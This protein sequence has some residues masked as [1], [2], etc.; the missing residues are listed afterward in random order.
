MPVPVVAGWSS[1]CAA[2]ASMTRPDPRVFAILGQRVPVCSQQAS[3]FRLN[4]VLGLVRT[5]QPGQTGRFL[6][7]CCGPLRPVMSFLHVAAILSTVKGMLNISTKLA[8][9]EILVPQKCAKLKQ[10]RRSRSDML[11]SLALTVQLAQLCRVFEPLS[12]VCCDRL[13]HVT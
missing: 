6:R 11:C 7:R 5:V 4:C 8:S 3:R 1:G 12:C 2:P 13:Q 10:V 9:N